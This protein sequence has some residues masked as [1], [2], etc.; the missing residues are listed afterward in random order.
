MDKDINKS[1]SGFPFLV[2]I[3]LHREIRE[4]KASPFDLSLKLQ[5]HGGACIC[6]TFLFV[7][8][9]RIGDIDNLYRIIFNVTDISKKQIEGATFQVSDIENDTLSFTCREIM[10]EKIGDLNI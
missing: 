5:S 3:C 4:L 2:S 7:H 6:A 9:I 10:I 8:D 1:L